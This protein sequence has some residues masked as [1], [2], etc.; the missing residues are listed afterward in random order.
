MKDVSQSGFTVTEIVISLGI[1]VLLFGF[2]IVSL[3]RTQ[4]NTEIHTTVDTIA[5]DI[6]QQ[7][8]KAM[9]GDT[10]GRGVNDLY[11]VHFQT[12]SYVLFHGTTYSSSDPANSTV[13]LDTNIQFV[14]DNFPIGNLIFS[15]GSGEFSAYAA[16][17]N[18]I[19][20]KNINTNQ[21]KTIQVNKYGIVTNV[22]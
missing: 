1:A 21:T 4:S 2:S 8:I 16:G 22:N 6:K 10:E 5:A 13:N 14:N 15:K 7:Q 18:T 12:S 20:L 9:N 11:G 19:S 3:A 17:Q